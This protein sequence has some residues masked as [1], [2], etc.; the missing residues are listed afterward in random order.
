[1]KITKDGAGSYSKE[2]VLIRCHAICMKDEHGECIYTF[3]SKKEAD[4]FYSELNKGSK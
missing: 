1:M 4:E 3:K 2:I